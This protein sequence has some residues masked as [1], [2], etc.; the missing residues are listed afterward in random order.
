MARQLRIDKE[1]T[2]GALEE[3]DSENLK[4]CKP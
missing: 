3:L 4:K 2:I 1:L